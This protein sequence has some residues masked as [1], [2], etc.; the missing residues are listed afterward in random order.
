MI[1]RYD[2]N[3]SPNYTLND[4]WVY[5][6]P[7]VGLNSLAVRVNGLLAESGRHIFRP[8]NYRDIV[9]TIPTIVYVVGDGWVLYKH[10]DGGYK[11]NPDVAPYVTPR[12][13]EI[14]TTQLD[15]DPGAEWTWHCKFS[16]RIEWIVRN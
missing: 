2:D 15:N 13:S 12:A 16:P 1:R 5:G 14:G 10:F 11:L 3:P 6:G 7:R 8:T 9:P 4:L